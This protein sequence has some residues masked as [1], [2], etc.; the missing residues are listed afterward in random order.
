MLENPRAS[1]WYSSTVGTLTTVGSDN[2]QA[3][4]TISREVL[5]APVSQPDRMTPQRLHAD[6]LITRGAIRAYFQGALHDGTFSRRHATHR[7]AQ[8][9]EDWLERLRHML[10][11]VGHNS[12]IYQEGK[13]RDD[14]HVLETTA[15]FLEV[16]YDPLRLTTEAEKAAYL[17]GYFDAEGGMPRK[18]D[19]K[20]FQI[21]YVQKDQLELASVRGMLVEFG[22][23]CGKMHVPSV[24]KAPG[25]WRFFI[26]VPCNKEFAR[27]IGSW[28][29]R[30]E[31][32][33]GM[34]I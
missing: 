34:M 14:V 10:F 27:R 17:R 3:K 18:V 11:L 26:S 13:A 15:G 6:S 20:P 7:I 19:A 8:K 32:L 29:P 5:S 28:H 31:Q 22:I 9:G 16:K 12:W 1:W 23:R 25:Y 21:Q 4:R 24:V 2:P 30:K 33:L